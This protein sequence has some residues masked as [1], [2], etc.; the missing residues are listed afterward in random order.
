MFK[1]YVVLTRRALSLM[2]EYRVSMIIWM[3]TSSFPLIM[4]AV[5]LSLAQDGPVGNYSA[6]DFVAYYLLALYIREMTSVWV[7]WDLD[8]DI[9][10]GDLSIKLLHPLHPIHEYLATNLADKVMR[11]VVMTPLII[12]VAWLIPGVHYA[13]TPL[14]LFLFVLAL[15]AA[16]S[17]RFMIQYVMGLLSFW[18]S[19]AL[20]L[21]DIMWMLF[22]LLGGT[23]APIDLLPGWLATLARASPFRYEMSFPI[24][25]M[26]G[27]LST[28]ELVSGFLFCF[29]WVIVVQLIHIVVWR[30]GLRTFSAYGA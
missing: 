4:L 25:I 10:H 1:K 20:T 3:L 17:L 21:N 11:V 19:Q 16:W 18:I 23:V 9:R 28:S 5:W 27:R 6:G 29:G 15:L 8:T 26:Q 14:N 2:L 30:R 7:A 12:L 22:L 13:A 24:E